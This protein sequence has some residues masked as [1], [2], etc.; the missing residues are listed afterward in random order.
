ME[1]KLQGSVEGDYPC[2]E[3]S[4]YIPSQEF[5]HPI[6]S[7]VNNKWTPA[8]WVGPVKNIIP[9]KRTSHRPSMINELMEKQ[10][11]K[12]RL[13]DSDVFRG[14][15]NNSDVDHI[16]PLIYGGSSS[17]NN[18]QILCV[19]CHRRKSALERRKIVTNMGDP[20]IDW[21]SE[22]VYLVNTHIHYEPRVI[23]KANP[24]EFL[25]NNVYTPALCMLEYD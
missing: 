25:E 7:L 14:I 3:K 17:E 24:K 5:F 10:N 4:N 22:K 1:N 20:D 15:S 12:C 19:T 16:I 2:I 6:W 23:P 8:M 13:C 18:L 11:S 9:V 21:G